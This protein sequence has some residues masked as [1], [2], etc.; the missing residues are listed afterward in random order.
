L[1]GGQ[2]PCYLPFGPSHHQLTKSLA[3]HLVVIKLIVRRARWGQ[4]HE[5]A[6]SSQLTSPFDGSLEG[7]DIGHVY[8]LVELAHDPRRS[9]TDH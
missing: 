7:T 6:G 4:Q 1:G 3:S 9:L 8:D 2:S 5:I